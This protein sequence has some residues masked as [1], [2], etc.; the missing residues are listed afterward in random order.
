MQELPIQG[1]YCP[2]EC[3]GVDNKGCGNR[4]PVFT[5]ENWVHMARDGG[6]HPSPQCL[7]TKRD[8]PVG[9]LMTLFGGVTMQTWTQREAYESFTKIHA[10]QHD[11]VGEE[12]F[13]YSVWVGS[14]QDE[15][16]LAWMVSV[17]DFRLLHRLLGKKARPTR[18]TGN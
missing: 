12:K 10:Y 7:R 11:T 3:T 16:S 2:E 13:Q 9:T 17:N 6:L 8:I 1:C 4:A 15:G 14:E 5:S 18:R